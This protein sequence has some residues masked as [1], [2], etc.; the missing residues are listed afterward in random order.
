MSPVGFRLNRNVQRPP[1]DR[2]KILANYRSCDLSDAM[3]RAGTM[4]GIYPVYTPITQVVGPAIT[5]SVPAGGFDM[6]K[7]GIQEAQPGDVLVVSAQGYTTCALWGGNLSL[8]TQKRGVAGLIMDGA[9]RDVPEIRELGFPTF[10]RAT[11]TAPAA[12]NPPTGEVNVAIACGGVV[13]RPG[14]IVVADEDGI[15]IVPPESMDEIAAEAER[16]ATHYRS[17]RP[18]LER[19]EVTQIE[20]ITEHFI[21]EGLEIID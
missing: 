18:I 20:K 16:L 5:V 13:V 3:N 1:K 9:V 21:G 11:A 10:A 6:I 17:A 15:V 19:G 2:Y 4:V 7:L 14:D 12:I 8:G